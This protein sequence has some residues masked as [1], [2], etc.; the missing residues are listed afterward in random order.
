MARSAKIAAVAVCLA[1]AVWAGGAAAQV[2]VGAGL[3][4]MGGASGIG[5]PDG[6]GHSVVDIAHLT[7]AHGFVLQGVGVGAEAG[8]SVAAAGDMNGDGYADLIVGA[9]YASGGGLNAG[10]AYVVF[11]ASASPGSLDS[12]GRDVLD[13]GTLS[14]AHGLVFQ[15]DADAPNTT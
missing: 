7:P 15:G 3:A 13:L 12:N 2:K 5:T 10:A 14:P 11:G 6:S 8:S 9:P 1:A 4:I